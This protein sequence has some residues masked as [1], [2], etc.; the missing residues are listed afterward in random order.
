[1]NSSFSDGVPG[2]LGPPGSSPP[3]PVV[4]PAVSSPKFWPWK[5]NSLMM[6][7]PAA[8]PALSV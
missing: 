3:P 6:S 7:V 4:G 8:C 2:A 5:R 1:M